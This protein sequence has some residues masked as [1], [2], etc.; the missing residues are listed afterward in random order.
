MRLICSPGVSG[1]EQEQRVEDVHSIASAFRLSAMHI[2]ESFL[3]VEWLCSKV[4]GIKN[5]VSSFAVNVIHMVV[6]RPFLKSMRAVS[7][8]DC[9]VGICD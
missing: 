1:T 8:G 3:R 7:F 2:P 9:L 6:Q 5:L 4:L